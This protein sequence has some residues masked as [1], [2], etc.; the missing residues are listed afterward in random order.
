MDERRLRIVY[1]LLGVGIVA[2][3]VGVVLLFV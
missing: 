3:V 1:I 2:L